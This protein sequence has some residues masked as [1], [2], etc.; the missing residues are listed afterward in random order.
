MEPTNPLATNTNS[1]YSRWNGQRKRATST[2][3]HQIYLLT[4]HDLKNLCGFLQTILMDKPCE[5][6][7]LQ[8]NTLGESSDWQQ[9]YDNNSA[10]FQLI[11]NNTGYNF[12]RDDILGDLKQLMF[13]YQE[14]RIEVN[15]MKKFKNSVQSTLAKN[16]NQ[17]K[18]F[19]R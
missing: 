10:V 6:Y 15:T 19:L 1:Y 7:T 8:T 4:T 9:Y 11:G 18:L 12:S 17:W 5:Q 2:F 13:Y 14:F 16:L 3:K